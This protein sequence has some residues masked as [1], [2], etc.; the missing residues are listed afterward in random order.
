MLGC[1]SNWLDSPQ[2]SLKLLF[3]RPEL[4]T[5]P[6]IEEAA[7]RLSILPIRLNMDQV[8]YSVLHNVTQ[9]PSVSSIDKMS[10]C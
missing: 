5:Q 8:C 4:E 9:L 7:I 3:T 1:V 10:V 6:S 2:I